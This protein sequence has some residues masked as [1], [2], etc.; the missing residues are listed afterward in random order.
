MENKDS[1]KVTKEQERYESKTSSVEAAHEKQ[2]IHISDDEVPFPTKSKRRRLMKNGSVV[3]NNVVNL[4]SSDEE[5]IQ[6]NK[7]VADAKSPKYENTELDD[8]SPISFSRS[9]NKKMTTRSKPNKIAMDP[10]KKIKRSI[11]M[12]ILRSKRMK[13]LDGSS[14]SSPT[15]SSSILGAQRIRTKTSEN[16]TTPSNAVSRSMLLSPFQSDSI[17]VLNAPKVSSITTPLQFSST[18]LSDVTNVHTNRCSIASSNNHSM[19][20][21]PSFVT[22]AQYTNPCYSQNP[23]FPLSDITNYHTNATSSKHPITAVSSLA[24]R[25]TSKF[26]QNTN[27]ASSSNSKTT[28][29]G[30]NTQTPVVAKRVYKPRGK[31]RARNV[32]PSEVHTIDFQNDGSLNHLPE[33]QKYVGLSKEYIDFGEMTYTCSICNAKLWENE[34]RVGNANLKLTAY[35]MCC[36]R[37]KVMSGERFE[38]KVNAIIP[39]IIA[40]VKDVLDNLNPLVKNFRVA[41]DRY[42]E[43][44]QADFKLKLIGKRDKDGRQYNMPTMSEVAGLIVGDEESC[45]HD[46]D[47]VLQTQAGEFQRINIFHPSYL[48]L[49]YPVIMPRGQDGYRLGILHRGV[50][51]DKVGKGLVLTDE[52]KKN[53]CLFQIELLLRSNNSSLRKFEG[54]PYPDDASILSSNNRLIHDELAYNTEELKEEHAADPIQSIVDFTFPDLMNNL[55]TP[56]FLEGNVILAPTNEVVDIINDKLLKDMPGHT[57]DDCDTAAPTIDIC[58]HHGGRIVTT[59]RLYDYWGGDEHMICNVKTRN[60]GIHTVKS[61]ISHHLSQY[62]DVVAYYFRVPTVQMCEDWS[63]RKIENEFVLNSFVEQIEIGHALDIYLVHSRYPT[64]IDTNTQR[65]LH[66]NWGKSGFISGHSEAKRRKSNKARG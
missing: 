55:E 19:F 35:S 24:Q 3:H 39:E 25:K 12:D 53:F 31:T 46:R 20:K 14:S 10:N 62:N 42:K 63:L 2:V 45:K 66:R 4:S 51:P 52:Q 64:L 50:N 28:N 57:V 6:A 36:G 47:I 61:L 56:G 23:G 48:A 26:N 8:A 29:V 33:I 34:A 44:Q 32:N 5:N 16:T 7:E 18:P 43:N 58:V 37:G 54:M 59:N 49:Q 13:H 41:R 21:S 40:T 30:N 65:W 1:P 27:A 17:H 11:R 22:P 15:V 60:F 38:T 9:T